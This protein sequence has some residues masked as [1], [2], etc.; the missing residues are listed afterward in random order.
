MK[1]IFLQS[2]VG[3]EGGKHAPAPGEGAV[4]EC[5]RCAVQI[6]GCPRAAGFPRGDHVS[7]V[8][9]WGSRSRA[10]G[11]TSSAPA[12][13]APIR[14]RVWAAEDAHLSRWRPFLSLTWTPSWAQSAQSPSSGS[15]A[16]TPDT[17]Q[18]CTEASV[19]G[20]EPPTCLERFYPGPGPAT[21]AVPSS[22]PG[23]DAGCPRSACP[24]APA[25]VRIT[26]GRLSGRRSHVRDRG[27]HR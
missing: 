11:T 24:A 19:P 17:R 27:A 10:L 25:Q 6:R 2:G 22:T 3:D 21:W 18:P 16:L 13:P 9:P 8:P 1:L 20:P 14:T 23:L 7:Q 4:C 5:M 15:P 26:A 12:P